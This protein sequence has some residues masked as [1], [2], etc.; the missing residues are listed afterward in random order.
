[1]LCVWSTCPPVYSMTDY[2]LGQGGVRLVAN[3]LSYL[4]CFLSIHILL[5]DY[6]KHWTDFYYWLT[7]NVFSANECDLLYLSSSNRPCFYKSPVNM[8]VC[9]WINLGTHFCLS[10]ITLYDCWWSSNL[11][12]INLYCSIRLTSTPFDF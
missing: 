12:S 9:V 2:Q 3:P 4:F 10:A 1:M 6:W 5:V 8:N 11:V 7:E